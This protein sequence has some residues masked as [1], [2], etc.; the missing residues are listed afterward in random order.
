MKFK[1]FFAALTLAALAALWW[2]LDDWLSIRFVGIL[3]DGKLFEQARGWEL[4]TYVLP[5]LLTF[6]L[7]I[8]AIGAIVLLFFGEIAISADLRAE[9][10]KLKDEVENSEKNA[11]RAREEVATVS[12]RAFAFSEREA[13]KVIAQ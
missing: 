10:R 12:D 5:L 13:N 7:A 11:Q 8:G 1:L 6:G 4:A 9:I 3:H 2:W